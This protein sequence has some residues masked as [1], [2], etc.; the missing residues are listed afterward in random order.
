MAFS[1]SWK[2]VVIQCTVK[3]QAG[4][5][6]ALGMISGRTLQGG[7]LESSLQ[8]DQH[9]QKSH[10]QSQTH[11]AQVTAVAWMGT[12]FPF[13]KQTLGSSEVLQ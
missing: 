2:G 4:P 3:V 11:S 7:E 5:T 9:G 10:V 8:I 1:A 12:R 6:V 13:L